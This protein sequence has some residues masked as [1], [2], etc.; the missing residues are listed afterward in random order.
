M[1]LSANI[2]DGRVRSGSRFAIAA[3]VAAVALSVM[4]AWGFTGG[5]IFQTTTNEDGTYRL[6]FFTPDRF[7]RLLHPDMETPGFVRL[8]RVSDGSIIGTSR[9]V[10]FFGGNARVTWL[11]AMTGQ[12]SVGR[13]VMFWHVHPVSP[14]GALLPIQ[15]DLSP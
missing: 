13:D 9:V 4:L 14:S 15:H 5:E 7:N 10:D 6:D 8:Y 3:A 12:V 2:R 1:T 11:L